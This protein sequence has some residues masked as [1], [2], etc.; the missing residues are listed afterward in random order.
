MC[1]PN[2]VYQ[3]SLLNLLINQYCFSVIYVVALYS[4]VCFWAVFS[5]DV[6]IYHCPR[7]CLH[8]Y[9]FITA[10]DTWLAKSLP[11]IFLTIVLYV[12]GPLVLHINFRISV[13]TLFQTEMLLGFCIEFHSIYRQFKR[14]D[15]YK[16]IVFPS[17]SIIHFCVYSSSLIP[18]YK[19]LKLFS[20][21]I[22]QTLLKRFIPKCI[23][24]VIYF[25]FFFF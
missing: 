1:L 10:L 8:Y 11:N 14:G 2:H 5:I 6:F 17:L 21:N 13:S 20:I 15:L 3:H 25:L 18:F 19:T 7:Q 9:S 23:A 24:I 22:L 12:L 16:N 4:W